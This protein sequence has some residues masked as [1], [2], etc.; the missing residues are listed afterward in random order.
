MNYLFYLLIGFLDFSLG[1]FV[2]SKKPKSINYITF[3]L[4][5]IALSSWVASFYLIYTIENTLL[6]GRFTVFWGIL[7][8]ITLYYF[9]KCLSN[10]KPRITKLEIIF[11]LPIISVLLAT[12]PF[13]IYLKEVTVSADGIISFK[14]GYIYT[15]HALYY[16][17]TILYSI[18]YAIIKYIHAIGDKRNQLF[19]VLSSAFVI[20]IFGIV[21]NFLL[22]LLGYS[23]YN[24]YGTIGTF[25]TLLL[26]GLAILKFR[27]LEITVV[28]KK[29]LSY[30]VTLLIILFSFSIANNFIPNQLIQKKLAFVFLGV[31]WGFAGYPLKDFLI[32]TRKRLFVRGWYDPGKLITAISEKLSEEKSREEIF[33]I[34]EQELDEALQLE[35]T[36]FV[37]A[38]K[39]KEED[40][41]KYAYYSKE[42]PESIEYSIADVSLDNKVIQHF[43]TY[44]QPAFLKNLEKELQETAQNYGCDKNCLFI[45]FTSPENLEG[46]IILGERSGNID[47]KERD[48]SFFKRLINNVN[49][50]LYRLTPYEK[51]EKQFEANQKKLYDTQVQLIRAEKIASLA[52]TTQE[53]HH[54]IRT[55][56]NAIATWLEVLSKNPSK[57]EFQE[58]INDL[59]AQVNRMTYVTDTS[60]EL[61]SNRKKR[62][63][64]LNLNTVIEEATKLVPPSGYTLEKKL[65]EIPDIKGV[66]GDLISIIINLINN[67][68]SA[69]PE[70]GILAI[71]TSLD[72]DN[73]NVVI[74]ISDTGKGI[75]SENLEKI[76]EPYFTTDKTYGHGLGLSI[77]H[78]I[79][80]THK[81]VIQVE[82]T[83]GKGTVFTIKF[84]IKLA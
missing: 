31:F 73:S 9:I 61:A 45:P 57:E 44:P 64:K 72:E 55:P 33:K 6:A 15:L 65:L 70:G 48:L 68:K 20:I 11:F 7:I 19:L 49:A 51:I 40:L 66:K 54:E 34:I 37:I 22:P 63:E 26:F 71:K 52:Q 50:L 2:F 80:Q 77:V 24:I 58:F 43:T 5:S 81:G 8:P 69:M 12:L 3:F 17:A 23:E 47:Y 42:S 83:V 32:T 16:L 38:V 39:N 25:I 46:I 41:L 27:F 29:S 62:A 59:K 4:F 35:K 67:A 28:I 30:V 1:L 18:V 10:D 74:K 14:P 60:L 36:N 75:L 82:S 84:P 56:I 13:S 78:Q 21:F 76:W 53:C 79:I